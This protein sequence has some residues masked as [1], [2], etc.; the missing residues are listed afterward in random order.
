MA[1]FLQSMARKRGFLLS[2]VRHSQE[3]VLGRKIEQLDH[4]APPTY[5]GL[6]RYLSTEG[7]DL[8]VQW[9]QKMSRNISTLRGPLL[10]PPA[11]EGKEQPVPSPLTMVPA[12]SDPSKKTPAQ[13][14]SKRPVQAVLKK[15]KESPKKVNLVAA[16]VRG[17]RVEDALLQLSVLQK[18][19][20]ST[21]KR[22]VANARANATHNHG[23]NG[24]R[25][26][27]A[28]AFVGKGR[29]LKRLSYHA[30][31][32][33]GIMH[34]PSCRLTVVVK[35]MSDEQE[36]EIAR[37]RTMTFRERSKVSTRLIPHKLI[38]TTPQWHRTPKQSSGV[39]ES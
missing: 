8:G 32:R 39:L 35:E 28:E 19:A 3:Q 29:Y 7:F 34:H 30:K 25:L 1:A 23:L 13:V 9:H 36:A 21:V 4:S 16:L 22:V 24:D 20:A 31:G 37:Y 5:T 12:P 38:E 11:T 14:D 17:M 27:V 33:S 18:R 10:R 2:W 6:Q 26:F 15:I